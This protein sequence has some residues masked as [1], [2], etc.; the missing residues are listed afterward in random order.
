MEEESPQ[1]KVVLLQGQDNFPKWELS[2][3]TTLMAKDLYKYVTNKGDTKDLVKK[4][5][6]SGP[7]WNFR[8]TN[9]PLLWQ[10]LLDQYLA[11]IGAR[12]AELLQQVWTIPV[13]E[14]EDPSARMAAIQQAHAQINGTSLTKGTPVLLDKMLAC[15]MAMLLPA[16]WATVQQAL[17]LWSP[18][19]SAEVQSAIQAKFTRQK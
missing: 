17:W 5:T 1:Y 7:A 19:K 3:L 11:S 14:E 4:A 15:A 12:K 8:N 18:L 9:S 13:E 2:I 10:E 16:S 6:L